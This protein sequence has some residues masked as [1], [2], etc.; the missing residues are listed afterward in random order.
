MKRILVSVAILMLVVAGCSQSSEQET[1]TQQENPQW[2]DQL[3]DQYKSEPVGNPP[4]SIWQ[5]EYKGQIV[6]YIPQ[7][8]CDIPSLLY[9]ADGNRICSP[10]GVIAGGGDGKCPDFFTERAN[11][12]LIWKDTRTR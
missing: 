8:C 4:Q 5:Y 3:I 7:Q 9:D 6:Y 10:D 1:P 2:V 12:T 11:E